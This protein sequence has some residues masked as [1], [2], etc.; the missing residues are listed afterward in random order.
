ME[1]P[2]T[3]TGTNCCKVSAYTYIRCGVT[4]GVKTIKLNLLTKLIYSS[5][6]TL[7]K[8]QSEKGPWR[9]RMFAL[10]NF[11]RLITL[12]HRSFIMPYSKG[13]E[14]QREERE[15]NR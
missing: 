6:F 5:F 3:R 15:I 4:L 12:Y 9:N 8:Q 1:L 13:N 2:S 10:P 14:R 7:K 11:A